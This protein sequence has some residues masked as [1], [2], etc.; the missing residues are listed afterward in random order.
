MGVG[1][2]A[3]HGALLGVVVSPGFGYLRWSP[4]LELGVSCFWGWG[5]LR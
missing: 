3:E 4:S 2:W 5:S 1:P